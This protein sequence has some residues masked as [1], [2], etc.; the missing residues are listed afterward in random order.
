MRKRKRSV[1]NGLHRSSFSIAALS[2][3][4]ST[5]ALLTVFLGSFGY[6]WI[7]IRISEVLAPLPFLMGFPA[8]A[9]LTIGC[10]LANLFS[11]VGIPDLVFGPILTLLAVHLS[12]SCECFRRQYLRLA[13]LQCTLPSKRRNNSFRRI[14]CGNANGLSI[15]GSD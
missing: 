10:I 7:Q 1:R 5:Y 4:A 15:T 12:H 9:G 11:P 8:A 6:S 2:L 3:I 14:H 13:I